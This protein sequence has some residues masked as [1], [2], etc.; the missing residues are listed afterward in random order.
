[1][2]INRLSKLQREILQIITN[3]HNIKRER[4]YMGKGYDPDKIYVRGENVKLK[5]GIID[6]R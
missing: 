2:S 4:Y 5:K 1:M 6:L 3:I